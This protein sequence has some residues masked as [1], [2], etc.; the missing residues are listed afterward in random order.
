[1]NY[2]LISF[3]VET[4]ETKL[5]DILMATSHL[6]EAEEWQKKF[7]KNRHKEKIMLVP[8]DV[9]NYQIPTKY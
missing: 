5:P 8:V 6:H 1:M 3:P 9:A 7:Q 2:L 4:N